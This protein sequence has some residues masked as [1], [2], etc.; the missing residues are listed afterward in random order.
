MWGLSFTVA[1]GLR[2]RSHS[3]V[4]ILLDSTVFAVSGSRLPQTRGPGPRI[5]IP[6]EQGGP[7]LPL[8]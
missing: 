5:Y 1:G 7:V 4:R 3:R 8:I 6:Q 2:Q